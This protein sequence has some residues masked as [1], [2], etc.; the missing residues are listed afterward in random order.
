MTTPSPS[1][2]PAAPRSASSPS[3]VASVASVAAVTA[4]TAVASTPSLST[5]STQASVPTE[6]DQLPRIDS[7]EAWLLALRWGFTRAMAGPAR[8]IVC[9]DSN[10]D[11]WPLNEAELHQ[12]LTVWLRKPQRQLVLLAAHFEHVP[13]RHPRF[14]TWRPAWAHAVSPLAAPAEWAATLPSVLLDDAG[15]VVQLLDPL[16]WRGRASTDARSAQAA[17][18]QVEVLLQRAETT[19]PAHTLGL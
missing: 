5:P 12:E 7:R 18:E 11:E 10:F 13:Q 1:T 2:N 19:F 4:V 15:T 3:S 17:R 9:V 16:L 6:P 14:M 8:R